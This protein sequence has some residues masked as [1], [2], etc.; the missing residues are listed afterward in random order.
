MSLHSL[1][2]R[3][4]PGTI[5]TSIPH[6]VYF[7]FKE[8]ASYAEAMWL[9][10]DVTSDQPCAE[11]ICETKSV[12]GLSLEEVK[13]RNQ[14]SLWPEKCSSVGWWSSSG[15]NVSRIVC[16]FLVP[17]SRICFWYHLEIAWT[18]VTQVV[19]HKG[20]VGVDVIHRQ[21][22]CDRL[23]FGSET[24]TKLYIWTPKLCFQKCFL[25]TNKLVDRMVPQERS[26]NKKTGTDVL[27]LNI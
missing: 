14:T 1:C 9:D 25:L 26:I 12:T 24:L 23:F 10:W 13:C 4:R 5:T 17:V 15:L 3:T 19:C 7:M 6:E 18:C 16:P 21:Q 20:P 27:I 22:E 8:I 11:W 2:T